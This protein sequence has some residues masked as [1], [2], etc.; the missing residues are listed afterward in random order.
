MSFFPWQ[1]VQLYCNSPPPLM[2]DTSGCVFFRTFFH[3]CPSTSL[4]EASLYHSMRP[5]A[6]DVHGQT[7]VHLAFLVYLQSTPHFLDSLPSARPYC[8]R[9]LLRCGCV[10]LFPLP[11]LFF[12]RF[13][14][15]P[16]DGPPPPSDPLCVSLARA[17]SLPPTSA[18]CRTLTPP[19]PVCRSMFFFRPLLFDPSL[20]LSA[21]FPHVSGDCKTVQLLLL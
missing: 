9:F 20:L 21:I 4:F 14:C 5:P 1:F 17:T 8:L 2:L 19:C 10:R 15:I 6:S 16:I 18:P 7:S 13:R 3:F 12:L 11:G